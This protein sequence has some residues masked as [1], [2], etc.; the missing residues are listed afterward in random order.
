MPIDTAG[1]ASNS[2]G[3]DGAASLS[4]HGW[5][6]PAPTRP[7]RGS[8]D[9]VSVNVRRAN[10]PLPTF[11]RWRRRLVASRRWFDPR[12]RHL[13]SE[14]CRFWRWLDNSWF[15][16]F[17]RRRPAVALWVFVFACFG[18]ALEVW[19]GPPQAPDYRPTEQDQWMQARMR[20]AVDRALRVIGHGVVVDSVIAGPGDDGA[21][22]SYGPPSGL[23]WVDSE[24]V[25][26]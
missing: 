13:K 19:T 23:I 20:D 7:R 3:G 24:A 25:F 26:S 21:L 12:S 4:P 14:S 10:D 9:L 18:L 8:R 15:A 22:A 16:T 11:R 6:I 1:S 5:R 17:P 2:E